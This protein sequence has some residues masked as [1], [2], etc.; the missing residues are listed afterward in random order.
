M[1][2]FIQNLCLK[3]C[4]PHNPIMSQQTWTRVIV[5]GGS[6]EANSSLTLILCKGNHHF[7]I[8]RWFLSFRVALYRLTCLHTSPNFRAKSDAMS[9]TTQEH[10]SRLTDGSQQ[11]G[12]EA[13][14]KAIGMYSI[15]DFENTIGNSDGRLKLEGGGFVI[16]IKSGTSSSK[17]THA[18]W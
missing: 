14:I 10:D 12:R 9:C 8:Y 17:A 15:R 11:Q 2:F 5:C 6:C 4:V 7:D 3:I 18:R 16:H 1:P 13:L